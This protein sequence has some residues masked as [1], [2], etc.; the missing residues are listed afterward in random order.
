MQQYV[1]SVKAQG[2]S[3]TISAKHCLIPQILYLYIYDNKICSIEY[4]LLSNGK[5]S[6]I[7]GGVNFMNLLPW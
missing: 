1:C 2:N 4:F 7:I 5:K 6:M 3:E